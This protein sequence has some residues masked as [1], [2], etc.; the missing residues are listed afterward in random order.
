MYEKLRQD[1]NCPWIILALRYDPGDDGQVLSM[2]GERAEFVLV[3]SKK[4]FLDDDINKKRPVTCF[5]T[6]L[7]DVY[8]YDEADN[9]DRLR[10]ESVG[11]VFGR[12][13]MVCEWCHK[14]G[15]NSEKCGEW[16]DQ[17]AVCGFCGQHGHSVVTCKKPLPPGCVACGRSGHHVSECKDQAGIAFRSWTCHYCKTTEHL[18]KDCPD[19]AVNLERSFK[20]NHEDKL[21]NKLF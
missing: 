14:E 1:P 15:C 10:T 7:N 19:F 12:C 4:V 9:K 17:I 13:L 2:K 21:E 20:V 3:V 8:P 11:F 6:A 18:E 5:R 16:E